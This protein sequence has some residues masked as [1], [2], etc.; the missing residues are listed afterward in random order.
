MLYSAT[1]IEVSKTTRPVS[2]DIDYYSGMREAIPMDGVYSGEAFALLL[3][4]GKCALLHSRGQK[5]PL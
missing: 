5:A 1:T 2:Q 4:L 3:R